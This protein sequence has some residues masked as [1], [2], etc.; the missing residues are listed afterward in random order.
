MLRLPGREKVTR[1]VG[2]KGG[3]G[4]RPFQPGARQALIPN[5]PPLEESTEIPV[6]GVPSPTATTRTS[7][8]RSGRS[9]GTWIPR[10]R[11]G[12]G[13]RMGFGGR[14]GISTWPSAA[15]AD[16]K[17]AIARQTIMSAAVRT[18]RQ[19]RCTEAVEA[20]EKPQLP[21]AGSSFCPQFAR[22]DGR[23][24]ELAGRPEPLRADC[25]G[26]EACLQQ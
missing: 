17:A 14:G 13:W 3:P 18:F 10:S 16:A 23:S 25:L 7:E 12:A 21:P 26:L 5:S 11:G 9:D 6:T 1:D 19:V 24:L 20:N 22:F 4:E 2:V 8:C 15:G